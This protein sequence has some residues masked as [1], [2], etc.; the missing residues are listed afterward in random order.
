MTITARVTERYLVDRIAEYL[1]RLGHIVFVNVK[2][3]DT[4]IDLVAIWQTEKKLVVKI[5]E[6]KSMPRRRLIQ[7]LHN[8]LCIGHKVAA[9]VRY[10]N[11]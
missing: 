5:V 11:C 4:E 6:V 2:M 7:Q 9:L 10:N 1:S 8:R 3:L